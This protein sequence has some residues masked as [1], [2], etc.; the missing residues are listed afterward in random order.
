MSCFSQLVKNIRLLN[1]KVMILWNWKGLSYFLLILQILDVYF[2]PCQIGFVLSLSHPCH[3]FIIVAF[4]D[5]DIPSLILSLF[6]L[7]LHALIWSLGINLKLVH[8][9]LQT[10]RTTRELSCHL[11]LVFLLLLIDQVQEITLRRNDIRFLGK[12]F[13]SEIS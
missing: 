13:R 9:I 4:L 10:F 11:I 2:E 12:C 8:R 3:P 5:L 7:F 1:L 6:W